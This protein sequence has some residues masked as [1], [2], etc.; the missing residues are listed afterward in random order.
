LDI[1]EKEKSHLGILKSPVA[2]GRGSGNLQYDI[3][4]GQPQNSILVFRMKALDPSIAMPEI[5]REQIHA[6]GVALIE[7]WIRKMPSP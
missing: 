1:Y 5:G 6:E 7:E 4:P 2:A 3:V